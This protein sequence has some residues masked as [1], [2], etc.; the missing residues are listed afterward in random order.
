MEGPPA[1]VILLPVLFPAAKAMGINP[2]HFNI[3]VTAAVGVGFFMPPLGV[4][5]L[6]ALRFGNVSVTQ[7]FPHYWPYAL[8]LLV[9]V[10]LIVLI[11]EVTL[12]LPHSAGFR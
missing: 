7:H 8:A 10:L 1:A 5:L 9:G 12:W 3:V 2:I 4:G 6:I 11:P